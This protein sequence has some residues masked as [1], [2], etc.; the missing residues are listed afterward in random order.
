MCRALGSFKSTNSSANKWK[1]ICTKYP[2]GYD[3]EYLGRN[4]IVAQHLHNVLVCEYADNN[5]ILHEWE[6]YPNMSDL[7]NTLR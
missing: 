4:M 7:L 2:V 1:D 6:F 3:F 5:G